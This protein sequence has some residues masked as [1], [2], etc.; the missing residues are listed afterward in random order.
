MNTYT[1]HKYNKIIGI[2]H[3]WTINSMAGA[4][5]ANCSALCTD[6]HNEWDLPFL[7]AEG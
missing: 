4:R 1:S 5:D 3:L 2:I 6:P 7:G